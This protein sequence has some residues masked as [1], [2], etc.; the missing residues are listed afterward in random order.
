MHF[1]HQFKFFKEFLH[2][3]ALIFQKFFFFPESRSIEP[4][5][6]SI[7][8]AIKNFWSASV[9]FDRCSI[10]TGSIEAFSIN[11]T[12]FSINRKPYREFLKNCSSRVQT[13]FF[14]K[15]STFSLSI[16][17]GQGSNPIFCCFPSF[18]L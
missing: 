13:Y 8:I 11:Q 4:I 5:F 6:R 1:I 17:L 12:Y 2:K 10:D 3:L 15:F 16:R 7:K 9:C 14:K 18:F